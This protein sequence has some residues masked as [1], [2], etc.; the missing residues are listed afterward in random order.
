MTL[1]YR[2]SLPYLTLPYPNANYP[3]LTLTLH[4]QPVYASRVHLASRSEHFRAM[5]YGG[6]RESQSGSGEIVIQVL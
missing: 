5:L 6:M 4:Y 3:T 1:P 2:R